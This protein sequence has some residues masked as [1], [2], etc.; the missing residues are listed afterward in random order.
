MQLQRLLDARRLPLLQPRRESNP[1]LCVMNAVHWPL[2]Y[3]AAVRSLVVESLVQLVDRST[4]VFLVCHDLIDI[5]VS[6]G[7]LVQKRLDLVRI[8]VG[9]TC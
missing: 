1:H 8:R 3:G 5:L 4:Q 6:R 7:M 2:C 9:V